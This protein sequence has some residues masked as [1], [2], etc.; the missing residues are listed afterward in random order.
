VTEPLNP[1]QVAALI[2]RAVVTFL[3]SGETAELT[4]KPDSA[5][6]FFDRFE[7]GD[8]LVQLRLDWTDIDENG[9]PTLD[10]DFL[11]P[12]TLTHRSTKGRPHHTSSADSGERSYEW[13]FEDATRWFTVALTWS[14]SGF[15]SSSSMAFVEGH[16]IHAQPVEDGG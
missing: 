7:A 15:A 4:T 11:D 12:V 5:C 3:D 10:A 13:K 16:V 14:A 8:D 9:H 1:D 6:L 2:A